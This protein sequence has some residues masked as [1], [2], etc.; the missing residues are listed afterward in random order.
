MA[1]SPPPLTD[2][3]PVFPGYIQKIK[4]GEEDFESLASQFSDCSSAKAGGDLGAF[5]RGKSS[6]ARRFEPG[7]EIKRPALTFFTGGSGLITRPRSERQNGFTPQAAR[8][9]G[10]A[11]WCLEVKPIRNE[12]GVLGRKPER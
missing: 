12:T 9:A 2:R 5:G 3:L 10:N 7:I 11:V 1:L 8:Y 4:S 6:L